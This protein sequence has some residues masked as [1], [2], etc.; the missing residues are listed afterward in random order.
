MRNVEVASQSGC[1]SEMEPCKAALSVCDSPYK[2]DA[3]RNIERAKRAAQRILRFVLR[4]VILS[5]WLGNTL[6]WR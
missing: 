3:Q 5:L 2:M 1:A 4:R 6:V